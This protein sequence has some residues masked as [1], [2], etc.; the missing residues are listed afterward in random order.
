MWKK[1]IILRIL[2]AVNEPL[3]SFPSEDCS[4]CFKVTA[5]YG[6]G[7]AAIAVRD[8]QK[9]HTIR[10][11]AMRSAGEENVRIRMCCLARGNEEKIRCYLQDGKTVRGL[12]DKLME[13][14][15]N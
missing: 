2:K 12:T 7:A 15:E 13:L 3:S 1:T 10:F 6:G 8:G 5:T 14:L 9:E 4:S 11:S